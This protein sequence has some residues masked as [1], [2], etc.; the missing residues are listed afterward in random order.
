MGYHNDA[1]IILKVRQHP[2]NEAPSHSDIVK[3]SMYFINHSPNILF[4]NGVICMNAAKEYKASQKEPTID[5]LFGIFSSLAK[6]WK[7]KEFPTLSGFREDLQ[8]D[9]HWIRRF[10]GNRESIKSTI[11]TL[12]AKC[13]DALEKLKWLADTAS[14]NTKKKGIISYLTFRSSG[15]I[16]KGY[17]CVL[18]TKNQQPITL[19][20]E[21]DGH[22]FRMNAIG[23]L[24]MN[25]LDFINVEYLG[26]VI[27]SISR[28]GS[29]IVFT[30]EERK[31]AQSTGPKD[32]STVFS[33]KSN[34]DKGVA[35]T[36]KTVMQPVEPVVKKVSSEMPSWS[37]GRIMPRLD[38]E[39]M[40]YTI[41]MCESRDK[42]YACFQQQYKK[43]H[44]DEF[45]WPEID[46]EQIFEVEVISDHFQWLMLEKDKITLFFDG[47]KYIK[48]FREKY[49]ET[50]LRRRR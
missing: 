2:P 27:N 40:A 39:R 15:E 10:K 12:L 21:F 49:P 8:K 37:S 20:K 30:D 26:G 3:S 45:E 47:R 16:D 11:E 19:F 6:G 18:T 44:G 48:W 33:H 32:W 17:V 41:A 31:F 28:F 13:A 46:G 50:L 23:Y 42:G 9:R 24:N 36:K 5:V 1:S 34:M 43:H 4:W 25:L 29:K 38:E 35:S 22:K 7:L 14:N